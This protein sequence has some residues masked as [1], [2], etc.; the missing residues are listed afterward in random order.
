MASNI[1]IASVRALFRSKVFTATSDV[2]GIRAGVIM[3]RVAP[4]TFGVYSPMHGG[5]SFYTRSQ[6][7]SVYR[8]LPLMQPGEW[9]IVPFLDRN[10]RTTHIDGLNLKIIEEALSSIGDEY[11]GA[12]IPKVPLRAPIRVERGL[13]VGLRPTVRVG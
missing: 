11:R 7:Q 9:V 8:A 5:W 1:R 6:L 2:L 12:F 13:N 3:T 10:D 4:D